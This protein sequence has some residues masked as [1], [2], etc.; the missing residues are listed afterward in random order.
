V[1]PF[2]PNRDCKGFGEVLRRYNEI[3]P[4]VQLGGPTSFAP[5]LKEAIRIVKQTK[6]YHILVMIADGTDSFADSEQQQWKEKETRDAVIEA[7]DYPL[8]IIM[9]GV[10]DGPFGLMAQLDDLLPRRLFDN[11]QFVDYNATLNTK[12]PDVNFALA[13]LEEIPDQ[14]RDIQKLGLLDQDA[15]SRREN[16]HF[17]KRQKAL[18]KA[19]GKMHVASRKAKAN[20]SQHKSMGQRGRSNTVAPAVGDYLQ[21]QLNSTMANMAAVPPGLN[22]LRS[23]GDQAPLY[24]PPVVGLPAQ[25]PAPPLGATRGNFAASQPELGVGMGRA[26]SQQPRPGQ[27]QRRASMT[28]LPNS[29]VPE[30]EQPRAPPGLVN[31]ISDDSEEEDHDPASFFAQLRKQPSVVR[32]D[33][34]VSRA[35]VSGPPQA[36]KGS[37]T[38]LC[39]VCMENEIDMLLLPCRHLVVCRRC[40]AKVKTCPV[41][42]EHIETTIEVFQS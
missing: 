7:A 27:R 4:H 13:A 21:Q 37:D 6:K 14:Y 17:L 32:Q 18:V 20:L 40:S 1:F 31:G 15:Q 24:S 41:C 36:N 12:Y 30:R 29:T 10:G 22:S 33:P 2:I 3:T 28:Q 39:K 38:K 34:T 5:M 11:F 23:P 26:D 42:R 8:S 25:R 16:R 35:P 9:V 19:A